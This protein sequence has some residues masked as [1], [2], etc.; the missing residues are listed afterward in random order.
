MY[1]YYILLYQFLHIYLYLYLYLYVCNT[2]ML[3]YLLKIIYIKMP[4]NLG[5]D[6]R[7]F[8][9]V[10]LPDAVSSYVKGTSLNVN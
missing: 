7:P 3:L 10:P 2:L 1:L 4:N 8:G 6:D 5:M 9:R